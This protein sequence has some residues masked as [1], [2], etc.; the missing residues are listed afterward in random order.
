[1]S[2]IPIHVTAACP[3]WAGPSRRALSERISAT[4]AE[5]AGELWRGPRRKR[6]RS[7]LTLSPARLGKIAAQVFSSRR[8]RSVSSVSTG[9]AVINAPSTR[10][11]S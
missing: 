4:L 2:T 9:F 5:T 8:L 7:G 11:V 10:R 1:M 3:I 6:L